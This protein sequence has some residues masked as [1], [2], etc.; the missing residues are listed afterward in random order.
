MT[1]E[2]TVGGVGAGGVLAVES[3]DRA[4]AATSTTGGGSRTRDANRRNSRVQLNAA[5]LFTQ[6]SSSSAVLITFRIFKIYVNR[7]V[8]R[9]QLGKSAKSLSLRFLENEGLKMYKGYNICIMS[10]FK[11]CIFA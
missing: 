10:G 5:S 1:G 8:V 11:T 7:T 3:D 2:E 4:S 9:K 6:R